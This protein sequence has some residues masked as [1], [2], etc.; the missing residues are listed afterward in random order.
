M[1]IGKLNISKKNLIII[2]IVIFVIIGGIIL[3]T[4]GGSNGKGVFYNPDKN[5]KI[6]KSKAS[7][8]EF[9]DY[10]INEFSIKKPKGWKVDTIGDYIHYTIKVYD[11]N[12]PA[13]QFFLNMK[14]EGY[15]K[16]VDAK[17]W[18]Q[19]Y[20]PNNPFAKASVIATKNTEGFY[21]I[22]N[23]LG[24]LNNTNT[25]TFP[26][27]TD[28]TVIDN[29]GKASLGGDML[30]ATFKDANGKEGEGIFTAYVYDVGSY[31]VLENI[32]SGKKIDIQYLNVY[33]AIFIT[34]PKDEFIDW[35]DT[36]NTICSS[37][38]FTDTFING[39]NQQQDAV[40]KNF[41]QIRAI[42]N[43]ISDGIMDSW[44]KRNTSFDIMSQKQSDATLGY[45]RV[46][47]TET[48]EI[49]KAYNGFTDDYDGERYKPITDDM[50]SKKTSGI[51]EK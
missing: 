38:K 12:N 27:L 45:E 17:R 20:Y 41:Q 8:I 37:L 6:A 51:I 36:L 19:K 14:T 30:R 4:K 3:L 43:E 18:Q 2:V 22:F 16:S 40:M 50:Y 35:Q 7:Q 11:P 32:I 25:F 13:Y 39:F 26:T 9:E 47:D 49:Y 42:G 29:L 5:I 44:N 34:A 15:N 28:F 23:D 10:S 24:T 31:Y 21:K 48:N 46:Y 33:D 1:K